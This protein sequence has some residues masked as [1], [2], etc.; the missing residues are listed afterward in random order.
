MSFKPRTN[1]SMSG[2]LASGTR[3][4]ARGL[5]VCLSVFLAACT[6]TAV[7]NAQDENA[8]PRD[9][10]RLPHL[11]VAA[12]G[13]IM[14]GSDFPEE[15]LPP[16]HISILEPVAATLREA[17]I[18]FGNLEGVIQDGGDPVKKCSSK[19]HCYLFRT[20]SRYVAQLKQAGFDVLNLANNHAKDFGEVGRDNTMALLNAA[21]IA[22][23]GR[24]GDVAQLEVNGSKVAVIGFAP[25][26]GSNNMLLIESAYGKIQAL[27]KKND[28]VIVSFHGGAEGDEFTRLP[29]GQEFFHGE[30]RGD[31]VAFSR[32][33]VDAGADL[34]IGH[35]PH[36]PRALELYHDRLIAYSLGNFATYWGI[37]V[38]GL[39]GVA[40]I[41][42]AT[43]DRDGRFV[44]G[45]LTSARQ[46]RP[47]GPL[48]DKAG[49]A[50]SVMRELTLADFPDTPLIIDK[51]GNI[52]VVSPST[53]SG[54]P[55]TAK[56]AADIA[57]ASAQTE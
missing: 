55:P 9:L 15:R 4:S 21:G 3:Y 26:L 29:F 1:Y 40:P 22:H 45:K 49:T 44:T 18:A 51:R 36:V 16:D 31:V 34:V 7:K 48:P 42:T 57:T 32:M 12:V 20:P 37:K 10:A 52:R 25:Y 50:V 38:S 24:D 56:P 11:Q 13:D 39:N 27:A 6:G 33:A 2:R 46:L 8:T 41:L 19:K 23:T 14:L 5:A 54:A 53:I 17:D 47:A 35:G 43:L 30:D 28:I